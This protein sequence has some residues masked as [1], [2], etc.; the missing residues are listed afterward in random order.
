MHRQI[1]V[2]G[3]LEEFPGDIFRNVD[4]MFQL[5][6][7]AVVEP[8]G[9]DRTDDAVNNGFGWSWTVA[10]NLSIKSW[11]VARNLSLRSWKMALNLSLNSW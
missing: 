2:I 8:E 5:S 6:Q 4:V 7:D 1:R 3:V 9:E 11:E 10:K